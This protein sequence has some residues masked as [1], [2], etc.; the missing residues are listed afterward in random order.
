MVLSNF[1]VLME[2]K[3]ARLIVSLPGGLSKDWKK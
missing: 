1:V 2:A 3:L